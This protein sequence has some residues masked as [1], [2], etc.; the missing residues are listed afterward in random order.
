M[1]SFVLKNLILFAILT[2]G[3]FSLG[4]TSIAEAHPHATVDLM[5]THSHDIYASEDFVIHTFEHVV[6]FIEQIQNIFFS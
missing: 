2:I 1:A 6:L 4:F 3:V 5:N